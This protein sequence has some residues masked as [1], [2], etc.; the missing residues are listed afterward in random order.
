MKLINKDLVLWRFIFNLLVVDLFV[1]EETPEC[2]GDAMG[3]I[4]PV[5]NIEILTIE[6]A[7][8][9]QVT[10]PFIKISVGFNYGKA[11]QAQEL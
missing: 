10:T 7:F 1:R 6:N 9:I 8:G 2:E 5:F 11:Q 3:Y 4:W